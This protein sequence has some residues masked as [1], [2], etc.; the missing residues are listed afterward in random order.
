MLV[1]SVISKI[2]WG[3]L[4]VLPAVSGLLHLVEEGSI[5]IPLWTWYVAGTSLVIGL[6]IYLLIKRAGFIGGK[7]TKMPKMFVHS[8]H[9]GW[10]E[11][12][13]EEHF[14]VLWQVRYL[15]DSFSRSF[16]TLTP[17]QHIKKLNIYDSPYCPKCKTEMDEKYSFFGNF[18]WGKYIWEC[19]NC[20]FKVRSKMKFYEAVKI[21]DKRVKGSARRKFENQQ[22]NYQ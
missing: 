5:V 2:I 20:K 11:Y 21:V 9:G 6:T 19:V 16:N 13:Y 12:G 4:V 14:R 3:F 15:N 18:L 10:R 22:K 17:E 7:N 8:P 1:T